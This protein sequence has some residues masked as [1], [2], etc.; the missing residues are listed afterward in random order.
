MDD[1]GD[2]YWAEIPEFPGY[3]VNIHGEVLN[4]RS[5]YLL[6]HSPTQHGEMTVGMMQGGVQ[7]RRSVKVLVANAFVPGKNSIFDTPV[8]LNGV[9]NDLRWSNIVWRPRWFAWKYA[10][11]FVETNPVWFD[12]PV[13]EVLSV[14]DHPSIFHAAMS[15]GLLCSEIQMSC[16]NGSFVYPLN[17]KYRY[18]HAR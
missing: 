13:H 18:I 2:G 5:G 3:F 4:E 10:R 12:H 16:L 11:Q 9:R 17:H 6:T 1:H 7:K 14:T 15:H 8:L